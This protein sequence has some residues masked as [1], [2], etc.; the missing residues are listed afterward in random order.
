MHTVFTSAAAMQSC[1]H[2]LDNNWIGNNRGLPV[3][4]LS[5]CAASK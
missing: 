4:F 2:R 5:L 3:G 1:Y